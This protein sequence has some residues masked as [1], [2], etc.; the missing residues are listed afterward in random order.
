MSVFPFAFITVVVLLAVLLGYGA[1]RSKIKLALGTVAT[2]AIVFTFGV[3]GLILPAIDAAGS[4]RR[5]SDTIKAFPRSASETLYLYSPD[6]PGNEDIVYYLNLEPALPRLASEEMLLAQI[7]E[8]GHVLAVMDNTSLA[9]LKARP[10]LSLEVVQEFPQ[11]RRMDMHLLK[12]RLAAS[13]D[14]SISK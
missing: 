11:R 2:L 6:W 9:A 14:N 10:D 8:T 5:V 4:T 12:I 1:V 7:R 13:P 3:V